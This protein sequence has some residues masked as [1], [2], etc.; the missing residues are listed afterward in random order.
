MIEGKLDH[1]GIA[2]R[3]FDATAAVYAR[4][5]LRVTLK[6]AFEDRGLMR[7]YLSDG[8]SQLELLQPLEQDTALGRFVAERGGGLHHLCFEV[9]DLEGAI[10]ELAAEGY[11]LE[12][13]SPWRGSRGTNAFLRPPVGGVVLELIEKHQ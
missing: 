9:D 3:D 12:P 1:V 5:G 11:A 2:V 13:G 7:G 4:L 6:Q 8:A 10:A